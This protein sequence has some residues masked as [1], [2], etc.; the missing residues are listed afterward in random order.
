[1]TQGTSINNAAGVVGSN[2]GTGLQITADPANTGFGPF[3][4]PITNWVETG[5][6]Q[7]V[8]LNN[9]VNT[10]SGSTQV[11]TLALPNPV[12]CPG[13]TFIFRALDTRAHVLSCSALP[14]TNVFMMSGT[15]GLAGSKITMVSVTGSSLLMVSDGNRFIVLPGSGAL[16]TIA[17]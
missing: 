9:P 1:M 11:M 6:T 10:L 12:V 3:Q 17:G 14:T 5:V 15:V 8:G 16:P 2:G 7:S 4:S 13:A